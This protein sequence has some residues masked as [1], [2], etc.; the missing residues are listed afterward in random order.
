MECVR[1]FIKSKMFIIT[2]VIRADGDV[3]ITATDTLFLATLFSLSFEH[4]ERVHVMTPVVFIQSLRAHS[5][6]CVLIG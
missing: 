5:S 1:T 4:S 6:L 2:E 3:L